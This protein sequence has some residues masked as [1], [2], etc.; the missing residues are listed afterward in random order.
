[1]DSGV[2][3]GLGLSPKNL[4]EEIVLEGKSTE[5]CHWKQSCCVL[6]LCGCVS[7]IRLC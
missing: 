7:L 3:C 2:L 1:M 6:H 5:L 4:K